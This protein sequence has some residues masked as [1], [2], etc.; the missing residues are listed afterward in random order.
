MA[1]KIMVCGS[2][3]INDENL[4][5]SKLDECLMKYPD[6][7]LVSGGAKGVDSIGEKWAK[8]NHVFIEQ[9]KPEWDKYGR[10]AGIVRNKTMVE[11]SSHVLIFWDGV[12]KGTKSDIDFCR[13]LNK[14]FSLYRV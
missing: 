7:I 12:S 9:H 14:P 3:T 10:G 2:R 6:M 5:F 11:V 13:K 1:H 8:N 4:I